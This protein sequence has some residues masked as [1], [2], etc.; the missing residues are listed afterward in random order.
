MNTLFSWLYF[1][2]LYIQCSAVQQCLHVSVHF[3]SNSLVSRKRNSF[4]NNVC[5][6]C[7]IAA[8]KN[9][10]G[11]AM[12]PSSPFLPFPP[13]RMLRTFSFYNH[14]STTLPH[15]SS[16]ARGALASLLA[17]IWYISEIR[18]DGRE[19]REGGQRS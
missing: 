17:H 9:E 8:M 18:M 16:R 13:L 3:P 15:P 7:F 14:I 2:L 6:L 12:A 4:L 19:I 5:S 1:L 10:Y 11:Y